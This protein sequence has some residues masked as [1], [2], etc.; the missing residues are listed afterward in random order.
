MIL[1]QGFPFQ[2]QLLAP[3]LRYIQVLYNKNKETWVRKSEW[4]QA[5]SLAKLWLN[6]EIRVKI[7]KNA[8]FK[9]AETISVHYEGTDN[10]SGEKVSLDR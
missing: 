9:A 4:K 1:I 2:I 6:V 5:F 8:F 3:I 10:L 7:A